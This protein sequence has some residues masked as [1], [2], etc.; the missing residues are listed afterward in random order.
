M[1]IRIQQKDPVERH[2]RNEMHRQRYGIG[3]RGGQVAK[4]RMSQSPRFEGGK[5][6]LSAFHCYQIPFRML[7]AVLNG[8]QA[9]ARAYLKIEG[10][11]K[12][13]QTNGLQRR[14]GYRARIERPHAFC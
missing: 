4:F 12:T 1:R 3:A 6:V 5:F 10:S 13:G 8:V 2:R 7:L 9:L 14:P 11:R